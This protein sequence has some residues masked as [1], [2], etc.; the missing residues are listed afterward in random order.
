MQQQIIQIFI[1]ALAYGL[2]DS[3]NK[4]QTNPLK[5]VDV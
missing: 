5:W 3:L 4:P 2:V 1:C